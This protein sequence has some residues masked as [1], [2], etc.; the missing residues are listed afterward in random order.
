MLE[1]TRHLLLSLIGS[2]VD[3][4]CVICGDEFE[5]KGNNLQVLCGK[6]SCARARALQKRYEREKK[7]RPDLSPRAC[8]VC[9]AMFTPRHPVAR[10]CQTM[11]CIL[12]RKRIENAKRREQERLVREPRV[13]LCAICGKEF[14][15]K[16]SAS[17]HCGPECQR[18][19]KLR[20]EA[21]WREKKYGKRKRETQTFFNDWGP[22]IPCP[23]EA[24]YMVRL[25]PGVRS[26]L[27]PIMDPMS[28]G[29]AMPV[30]VNIRD[31]KECAA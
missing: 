11:E 31:I 27:D 1:W 7:N 18:T 24:G 8:A 23:W 20:Q 14:T 5:R 2:E 15:P 10:V 22:Q 4:K 3:M 9:G 19:N 29:M 12:A 25:E 6:E 13:A 26:W 21:A 28:Y 30:W 16:S 17:R